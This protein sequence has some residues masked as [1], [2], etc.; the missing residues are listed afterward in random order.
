[1]KGR[2][3]RGNKEFRRKKPVRESGWAILIIC[4]GKE[5]ECAYFNAI[6][7]KKRL[8]TVTIEIFPGNRCGNDPKSLVE[9]AKEKKREN[10]YDLIWCVFDHDQR[11]YIEEVLERARRA[12]LSVI[13]SNP[14]FELWYL[15]HYECSTKAYKQKQ[16]IARL[17]QFMPRYD[18]AM[19]A[20]KIL[21]ASQDIAIHNAERLRKHHRSCGNDSIENPSTDMDLIVRH[22]LSLRDPRSFG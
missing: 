14:C 22:L 13:C 12:K 4:E 2:E 17:G 1:M 21:E 11:E 15:L 10:A 16:L 19:D 20:Y 3:F 7:C 5:T 18:K 6:R 8:K 9:Y